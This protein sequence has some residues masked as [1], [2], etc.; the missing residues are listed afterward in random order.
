LGEGVQHAIDRLNVESVGLTA[1]PRSRGF[2]KTYYDLLMFFRLTGSGIDVIEILHR[3]MD[4]DRH[5]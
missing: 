1:T 5:L 2:G 3:C 4:F